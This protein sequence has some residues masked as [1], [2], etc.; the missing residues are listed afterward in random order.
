MTSEEAA[1][2]L[3]ET[4]FDV[5]TALTSIALDAGQRHVSALSISVSKS[6]SMAAA[7]ARWRP[8]LASWL[9]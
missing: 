8:Q 4:V 9:P 3:S 2:A 7:V 6:V 5:A 1:K